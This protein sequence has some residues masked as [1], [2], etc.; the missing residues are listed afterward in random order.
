M[1]NKSEK[2]HKIMNPVF[3]ISMTHQLHLTSE[4]FFIRSNTFVGGKEDKGEFGSQVTT[5]S[6]WCMATQHDWNNVNTCC[7]R[8]FVKSKTKCILHSG[9][10]ETVWSQ[11]FLNK[12]A[13]LK[14]HTVAKKTWLIMKNYGA[15]NSTDVK[16]TSNSQ[17]AASFVT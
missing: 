5:G 9:D 8:C 12:R 17:Y 1:N 4:T 15:W 14:H 3:K 7:Q 10:L 2:I 6:Y 16:I 11:T 13:L